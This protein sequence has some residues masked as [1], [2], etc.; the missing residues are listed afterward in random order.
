MELESKSDDDEYYVLVPLN[1]K[2]TL[3]SW[4]C[5]RCTLINKSNQ[6][7]C[8]ACENPRIDAWRCVRCSYTNHINLSQCTKCKQLRCRRCDYQNEPGTYRCAM[9]NSDL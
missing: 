1:K 7:Q 5:P 9:C 2:K 8:S 4:V 3:P 6:Y